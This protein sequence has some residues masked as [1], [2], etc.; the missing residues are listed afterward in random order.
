MAP[1]VKS[2]TS[3][4]LSP[5]RGEGEDEKHASTPANNN[6]KPTDEAKGGIKHYFVSLHLYTVNAT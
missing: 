1:V 2:E 4:S 6:E 3:P 5:V